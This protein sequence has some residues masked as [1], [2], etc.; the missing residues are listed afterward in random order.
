VNLRDDRLRRFLK[1]SVHLE[2]ASDEIKEYLA[3]D[4][5][6]IRVRDA[7]LTLLSSKTLADIEAPDS[8][9]HL[10]REI[11]EELNGL[12]NVKDSVVRVYFTNFQ[13]Q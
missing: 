11:R 6:R 8:K 5:N 2:L 10:R 13:V 7:L 4:Y 1:A 3:E 12:L 9:T